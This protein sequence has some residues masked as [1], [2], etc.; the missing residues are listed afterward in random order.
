MPSQLAPE[1][2]ALH[3][4]NIEEREELLEKRKKERSNTTSTQ[5]A[6]RLARQT[7]FCCLLAFL[8]VG[9]YVCSS[10]ERGNNTIY[11]IASQRERRW[12]DIHT[13]YIRIYLYVY[14][15]GIYVRASVTHSF[16][17]LKRTDT[18]TYVRTYVHTYTY[19]RICVH[20]RTVGHTPS[21][22]KKERSSQS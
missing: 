7:C 8:P 9:L 3:S 18:Y 13:S 4:G 22:K 16:K 2:D 6:D 12:T 20:T 11:E 10:K 21:E 14:K 15:S 1:N 19:E 17:Q 5:S